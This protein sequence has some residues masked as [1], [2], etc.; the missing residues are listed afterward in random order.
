[1][2]KSIVFYLF[3]ILILSL[4]NIAAQDIKFF[5]QRPIK[6]VFIGIG[7]DGGM[8][9]INQEKLRLMSFELL[10][11]QKIGLGYSK[12]FVGDSLYGN[13][14]SIPANLTFA[15]GKRNHMFE[16]GF[17]TT[18]FLNLKDPTYQFCLY[19]IFGYRIQPLKSKKV[20]FRLCFMIPSNLDFDTYFTLKNTNTIFTPISIGLGRSF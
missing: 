2:Q 19:P 8:G 9:S 20:F 5:N 6:N 4:N 11:I 14:I 1:M 18:I 7:G 15:I 12:Q 16:V 13:Y 3:F 17:G 10:M